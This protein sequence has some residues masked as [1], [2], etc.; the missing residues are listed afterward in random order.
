MIIRYK[1]VPCAKI[2]WGGCELLD[3]KRKENF[4]IEIGNKEMFLNGT[5]RCY[6]LYYS[7]SLS[8]RIKSAGEIYVPRAI[9]I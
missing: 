9:K 6:Y 7:V 1:V 8:A 2:F 3:S 4:G 5:F